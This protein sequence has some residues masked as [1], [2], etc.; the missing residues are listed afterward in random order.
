[1]CVVCGGVWGWRHV[2]RCGVE[3]CDEMCGW[4]CGMRCVGVE[5]CDE[6]YGGGGM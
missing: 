6:V 4:R 1:M 5:V 2:M 3:V